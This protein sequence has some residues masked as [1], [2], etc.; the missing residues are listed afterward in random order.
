MNELLSQEVIKLHLTMFSSVCMTIVIGCHD[1]I[2]RLP[3]IIVQEE[4]SLDEFLLGQKMQLQ[5]GRVCMS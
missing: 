4:R 2:G 5:C 1:E 3:V